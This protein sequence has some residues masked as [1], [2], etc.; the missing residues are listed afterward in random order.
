MSENEPKPAIRLPI[1]SRLTLSHF[2]LYK[3][4][5]ENVVSFDKNVLCIAGANGLGKSTFLSIL[6]YALTGTVATPEAKAL[7][8]AEY[9]RD[10]RRYALAY[11]EGRIDQ[12][13]RQIAEV[14]IQFQVDKYAYSVRRGMFNPTSLRSL[15]IQGP[16]TGIALDAPLEDEESATRLHE[17]FIDH[18]LKHTGLAQMDQFVY[19]QH[20]LLTFDERRHLL[21]WDAEIAR[22]LLFLVFGM[23]ATRAEKAG[24][25]IRKAD[26]MES[27]ARNAQYQATTAA[28]QIRDLRARASTSATANADL[29]QQHEILI[30]QRDVARAELEEKA[31]L[32]KDARLQLGII[33]AEHHVLLSDYDRTFMGRLNPNNEPGWHPLIVK[34]VHQNECGICGAV[35]VKAASDI[36][37]LIETHQCPLCRSAIA[38]EAD[39]PDFEMLRALDLKLKSSAERLKSAQ[40]TVSRLSEELKTANERYRDI[41]ARVDS[42]EASNAEWVR[43]DAARSGVSDVIQQL[44]HERR[45]ATERRDEFRRRRDEYR[46]L[47]E[48]V[49]RELAQ[50]YAEAEFEFLPRFQ[51][52]AQAFLGVDLYLT[53]EQK[54]R[55]PELVVTIAGSRRRA[56]NQLSESQRYFIDIALRMTLAEYMLR[57]AGSACLFID[58]PEGSLDIAYEQRAGKM[59]GEFVRRGNRLVMTANLN[60]NRLIRELAR[61]CGKS[62]M[63]VERMTSWSVLSEVQESAEELFDQLFAE[64]QEC[65]DG[66]ASE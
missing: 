56:S 38:Q 31:R 24:E 52:L 26:R 50:R 46:A 2:S 42:F 21:F 58:T 36:K 47:V 48:P 34:L 61:V 64:I 5:S 32:E 18:L 55:G 30:D 20:F 17:V 8:T 62:R 13:D 27:Q 44:Q 19:L 23:D 11:F 40:D 37:H 33:A 49:R 25:W 43:Q 51:A 9:Y 63:H 10:A 66:E 65:L 59:F 4:R 12:D 54:A 39:L 3:N 1:I 14:E 45:M 35:D 60:S 41:S 6:N 28:G 16:G 29:G 7:S 57:D 53:M 15:N 22:I